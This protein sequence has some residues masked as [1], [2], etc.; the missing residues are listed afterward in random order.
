MAVKIGEG[1]IQN[2][3][4][5]MVWDPIEDQFKFSSSWQESLIPY[6]RQGKK[7]TKLV[8]LRI[9]FDTDWSV[10]ADKFSSVFV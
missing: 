8:A 5:G 7:P 2:R 9:R 10:T 1:E 6:V 3:V 4:L